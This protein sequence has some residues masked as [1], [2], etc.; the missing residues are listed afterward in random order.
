LRITGGSY[1]IKNKHTYFLYPVDLRSFSLLF[2]ASRDGDE[3][4]ERRR[5]MFEGLRPRPFPGPKEKP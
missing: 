3:K 2:T 4:V 1:E 5:S